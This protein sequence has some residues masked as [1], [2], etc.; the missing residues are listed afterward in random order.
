MVVDEV[1]TIPFMTPLY[2]DEPIV[3]VIHQLCKDS[4]TAALHPL[5][6]PPGWLLERLLHR[7]Y[8]GAAR[9]GR[10]RAV[11]TVSESTRRDLLDLGYPKEAIHIVPNGLDWGFYLAEA[12]LQ[13]LQDETLWEALAQKA[14][15]HARQ[16]TWD[17]TAKRFAE[18]LKHH[19]T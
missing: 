2:A 12:I 14:Y 15:Q 1:N 10:V 8:A 19:A 4:W 18:T 6:Q 13:L 16:Y 17:A 11:V 5:A 9:R 3:E 7:V